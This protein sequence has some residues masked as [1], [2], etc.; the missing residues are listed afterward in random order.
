MTT[1]FVSCFAAGFFAAA[2]VA[3][4]GLAR[5]E[6][7]PRHRHSAGSH[8]H[9]RPRRHTAVALAAVVGAAATPGAMALLGPTAAQ[10]TPSG[11]VPMSALINGDSVTTVDG[12]TNSSGTPISLEQYAAQRV[13]YVVTVVSG[14]TW[15]SMSSA[16]FAKYQ[17]LIVGDPNCSFTA[18]SATSNAATWAP[19]AMGTSGLNPTVGNRVIVGTDPEYHYRLGLGGARPTTPGDPSTAG[20]EHLVQA[21]ITFAG[22]VAGATGV[23]FDTSC[24]DRGQDTA[25][26]NS[27]SSART[28]FTEDSGPPC[29][30]SV[31]F[32]ASNPVFAGVTDAN[33]QGWGCSDHI[34]YPAFPVDWQPLA[35]ATDTAS[36][37]TCGTD[38]DTG[39]TACGEAYVLVA[40]RGI[41]VTAPNLAL[42]PAT[43]SD[44]AGGAHTVTATVTE[45]GSPLSGALVTF[46]VTGQ[47]AG[48]S[49]T[50]VPASCTTGADGTVTFTYPDTNGAGTDTINAS[51]TISG[52]T[53]HATASETWTPGAKG[54][55]TISTTPSGSVPAGG[56]VSDGATLSGGSSPT[57][58]ITFTLYAPGDST[59]TKPIA[60]VT[61][62][63]SGGSASSGSVPV[64]PAG[65][66]RWVAT[67]GGDANNNGVA[68][69]CGSET[70][71]VT[72]A[73]P[74][75]STTPSG[76]VPA[77]G[78]A[79]DSAT[80]SGGFAPSGGVTFTLYAP[81]D[82][83][84]S[85]A[86]ATVTATLSGGSA[87]SGSV[88]VGPAGTYLWV[89][90]YGGDGNNNGVISPCGSET[91]TVTPRIL[92]GRAYGISANVS[93][94]GQPVVTLLP[95]PD[96]G[97]ITTTSSMTTSTPCLASISGPVSAN[98]LCVG[99]T[100]TSYP[101]QSS[102]SSSVANATVGITGIPTITLKAVQSTSTTTCG[103][104]SGTTT[105]DYL[106]VGNVIVFSQPTTVGPNTV[107]VVGP[108]TLV[109]NE[110]TP[111]TG[112]DKGLTVN[113]VHIKVNAVGLAQTDVVVASSE[114]DIGNCP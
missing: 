48:V 96:T 18:A 13:G 14:A 80:V 58:S 107:V 108:V 35:V 50:C 5:R 21:G 76:S 42:A 25:T 72:K 7:V 53:E 27:L 8:A 65:T 84:C 3:A 38:P 113:A 54:S 6:R 114:S 110:Q 9:R 74:S 102:A 28:G 81:G 10:A 44:P 16:D 30:G 79:S 71:V 32:I 15:D 40:G 55:P 2:L 92:T 20:A 95:S 22:G 111:I 105:I 34:T 90:T 31:Q 99:V 75:I 4:V 61:A 106:K 26:L 43:G 41:V 70:V 109:L 83:T 1:L 73:T 101:G 112:P 88:Q 69:P 36:H 45:G 66:Y 51:V 59:C 17:V 68:S 49:G 57:G 104:S 86:I 62:P 93:L 33:I 63:L 78:K 23:Y 97:P 87:S 100:T 11:Y 19:V 82:T 52:T 60:T 46:A 67:Y 89:A 91:V 103:G 98:V 24:F 64:G 94:I 37:P 77:G 47:N 85:K 29:G 12:I 39:A 56:S